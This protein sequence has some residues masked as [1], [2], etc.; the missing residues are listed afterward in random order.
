LDDLLGME[1]LF[2]YHLSD[3]EFQAL[4]QYFSEHQ[5]MYVDRFRKT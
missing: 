5:D 1:K 4:K 2:R 3:A